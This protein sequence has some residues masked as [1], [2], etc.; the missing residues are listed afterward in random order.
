MLIN[1][2]QVFPSINYIHSSIWLCLNYS[3]VHHLI[4]FFCFLFI[5]IKCY[6]NVLK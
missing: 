6:N 3:T 4:D 1:E 2:K 5:L